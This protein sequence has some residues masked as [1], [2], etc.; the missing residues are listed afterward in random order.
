MPTV[1][2][3]LA[4]LKS[5]GRE[6]TRQ[7]LARHGNAIDRVYGVSVADMKS[8]VKSIKGQQALACELY[9]SGM[10]E[11]MYIA[12]LVVDGSKLTPKQ[13][14]EWA[15]ASA[16]VQMVC[17]YTVPWVTNDHPEAAA[18]ALRWIRSPKEHIAAA[19]WAT[20]AGHVSLRPDAA[21][22]LKEI[23]ALLDTVVKEIHTAQNRVRQNMNSF[24]IT[25]GGY[26]LPLADQAKAAAK[27]IGEV[28][29]DVG[30][31]ACKVPLATEYIEKMEA[32]GKLGTK[33]KMLRC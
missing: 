29:V 22:N 3:I 23:Q 21:L 9:A 28:Y 26:V 31:T 2:S 20:Y 1:T 14:N 10:M 27:K 4:D 11:A 25:V 19:G 17:E 13:L 32:R 24:V 18:I 5:K 15:E 12:G 6:N 16:G 33:K 8:I 7:L 30:E